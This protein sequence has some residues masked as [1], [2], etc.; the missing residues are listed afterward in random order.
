MNEQAT[1]DVDYHTKLYGKA[2]DEFIYYADDECPI[3]HSRIDERGWCGCGTIG[4]D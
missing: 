3:C 2:A 1:D 4:G